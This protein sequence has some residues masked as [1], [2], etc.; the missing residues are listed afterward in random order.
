L[1]PRSGSAP[2]RFSSVLKKSSV[3][4]NT[5]KITLVTTSLVA[6]PSPHRIGTFFSIANSYKKSSSGVKSLNSL[7]T[8]N[9]HNK[10]KTK[11]ESKE[12]NVNAIE[13]APSY[14]ARALEL[15][16]NF[17]SA[18]TRT[19]AHKDFKV[20]KTAHPE[21]VGDPRLLARVLDMMETY[22]MTLGVRRYL[23]DV[24][25]FWRVAQ[26]TSS[27]KEDHCETLWKML[28]ARQQ[29]QQIQQEQ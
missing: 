21:L 14:V 20:L 29:E 10:T 13:S 22:P 6:L 27:S 8:E 23:L 4:H 11:G 9:N 3:V 15:F 18:I 17:S 7:L 25:N 2:D 12:A 26:R 1:R 24:N 19:D 28:D 5:S 16:S